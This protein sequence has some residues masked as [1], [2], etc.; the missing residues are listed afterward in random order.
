MSVRIS[1]I[2]AV[3]SLQSHLT[4]LVS[5]PRIEP[6]AELVAIS[7]IVSQIAGGSLT[8]EALEELRALADDARASLWEHGEATGA[9]TVSQV[10]NRSRAA[11]DR[12]LR[13][14]SAHGDTVDAV[15][16]QTCRILGVAVQQCETLLP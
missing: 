5:V 6:Y 16:R 11:E 13:Q 8:P 12:Y 14:P 3:V 15:L 4:T 9:I 2:P 7:D 1:Q 10:A